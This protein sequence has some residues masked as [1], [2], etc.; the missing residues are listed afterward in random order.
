MAYTMLEAS[1]ALVAGDLLKSVAAQAG[2]EALDPHPFVI[3]TIAVLALLNYRGVFMTL[4]VNFVITAIA[5][6]AIV[7]LF[8]AT[9]PWNPGAVLLRRDLLNGLPYGWIGVL[10][11]FQFGIWYYLGI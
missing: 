10:A 7:V 1:D 5:Y 4:S 2:P 11:A 9:P 3:L 8:I 6:L